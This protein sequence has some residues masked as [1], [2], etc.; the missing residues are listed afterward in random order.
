MYNYFINIACFPPTFN[1]KDIY[2]NIIF[3]KG[4]KTLSLEMKE[5]LARLLVPLWYP[6]PRRGLV[7]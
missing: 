5:P 2:L 7:R 6:E 3:H 4:I 1:K